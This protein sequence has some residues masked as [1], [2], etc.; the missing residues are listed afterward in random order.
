MYTD[1]DLDILATLP[2]P[3]KVDSEN[4]LANCLISFPAPP[5][6]EKDQQDPEMAPEI[7]VD[8]E[9]D[10]EIDHRISHGISI[11]CID[12]ENHPINPNPENFNNPSNSKLLLELSDNEVLSQ[13]QD[14]QDRKSFKDNLEMFEKRSRIFSESEVSSKSFSSTGSSYENDNDN[15]EKSMYYLPASPDLQ[16]NVRAKEDVVPNKLQSLSLPPASTRNLSG[17]S[18]NSR[19]SN[20]EELEEDYNNLINKIKSSP[21]CNRKLNKPI[22]EDT[23][24]VAELYELRVWV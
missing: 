24:T 15:E 14:L 4:D 3:I 13:S 21:V 17:S 19:N 23:S 7:D 11:N 9:R 2:A 20:L 1:I 16:L 6:P 8:P 12:I 18:R 10:P 5:S 22:I